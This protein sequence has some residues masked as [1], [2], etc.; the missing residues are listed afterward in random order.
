MRHM[1]DKS[2]LPADVPACDVLAGYISSPSDAHTWSPAEWAHARQVA[3]GIL[4]IHVAQPGAGPGAGVTAG[5]RS[6]QD[7]RVL[8]VP[9]GCAVCIDIEAAGASGVVGSGYARDWV[10]VVARSGFYPLIYTS[11]SDRELVAGI[12]PLWLADWNGRPALLP[13][14]VATQY[15]GGAGRAWDQSVISDLLPICPSTP[16]G[17]VNTQPAISPVRFIAPTHTGDGYWEVTAD[18][19]VYAFG[20]A[21]YLHG[22]DDPHVAHAPIVGVSGHPTAY[23]YW[24]V[25]AD[26][27]VFAY[28]AAGYHGAVVNGVV[29]K[30]A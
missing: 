11:A 22:P 18:G 10:A 28:G 24:I 14:T 16:G 25:A 17:T 23:G 30:P 3:A 12:A 4:P 27:G 1:L 2:F 26:G 8:A 13:G 29:K 5:V 21:P 7:A 19:H 9:N 15:D 6:V 20:D